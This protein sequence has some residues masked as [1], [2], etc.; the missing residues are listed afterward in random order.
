MT[1]ILRAPVLE[2]VHEAQQRSMARLLDAW[3]AE[4]EAQAEAHREA[5]RRQQAQAAFEAAE[6][7]AFESRVRGLVA[8]AKGGADVSVPAGMRAAS[9]L[10]VG[11]CDGGLDALLATVDQAETEFAADARRAAAWALREGLMPHPSDLAAAMASRGVDAP[12]AEAFAALGRRLEAIDAAPRAHPRLAAHSA[13]ERVDVLRQEVHLVRAYSPE[14][15]LAL[16]ASPR[17][18]TTS[19]AERPPAMSTERAPRMGAQ[20]LGQMLD[21]VF[22]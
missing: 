22:R 13:G 19:L 14:R 5:Q 21:R 1:S 10:A 16:V 7:A 8:Q 17:A 12:W 15:T 2:L 18:L 4:L 11:P 6:A 20:A 9:T 3:D